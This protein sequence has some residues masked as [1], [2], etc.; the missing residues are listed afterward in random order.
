MFS[1]LPKPTVNQVVTFFLLQARSYSDI[2][3]VF[4]LAYRVMSI[5]YINDPCCEPRPQQTL[6]PFISPQP[7]FKLDH[8]RILHHQQKMR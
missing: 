7:M 6:T 8:R 2:A 4:L 1:E 3:N 5:S